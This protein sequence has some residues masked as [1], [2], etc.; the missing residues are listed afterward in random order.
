MPLYNQAAVSPGGTR[1]TRPGAALNE[2]SR[3]AA[4]PGKAGDI[5]SIAPVA[6]AAA[7]AR[8]ARRVSVGA[9][10]LDMVQPS[11]K[12][13]VLRMAPEGITCEAR[14]QT[15]EPPRMVVG[16]GTGHPRPTSTK[17]RW[18]EEEEGRAVRRGR[19]FLPPAKLQHRPP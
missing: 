17:A 7:D 5:G 4:V 1:R 11:E 9:E 8:K 14:S 15:A 13:M 19:L 18:F 10:Y 16:T 3:V 2:I 6:L 12:P